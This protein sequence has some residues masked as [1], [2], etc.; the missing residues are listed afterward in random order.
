LLE[1][2]RSDQTDGLVDEILTNFMDVAKFQFGTYVIGHVLENGSD[3]QQ[4]R[5]MQLIINSFMDLANDAYGCAVLSKALTVAIG[6]EQHNALVVLVREDH[7]V[8]ARM[9]CCRLG[10]SGASA[11]LLSLPA[12]SRR[13]VWDKLLEEAP[14]LASNKFG[15]MVA[16]SIGVSVN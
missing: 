1:N 6:H 4:H 7:D 9:A 3:Q 10:H 11:C 2:C 12:S 13:E 15:Q 5:V 8:L 14:D 16:Q